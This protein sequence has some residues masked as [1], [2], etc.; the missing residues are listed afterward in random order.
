MSKGAI[1][2]HARGREEGEKPAMRSRDETR[3]VN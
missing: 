3:E 1:P 2:P